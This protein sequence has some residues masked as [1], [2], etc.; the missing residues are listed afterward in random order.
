MMKFNTDASKMFEIMRYISLADCP[1]RKNNRTFSTVC[2]KSSTI[3]VCNVIDE[4]CNLFQK[5]ITCCGL[6]WIKF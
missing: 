4:F 3:F 5:K 6:N 1:T 2:A